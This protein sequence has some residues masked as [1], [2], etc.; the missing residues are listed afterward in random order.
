MKKSL[1]IAFCIVL[2]SSSHVAADKEMWYSI[3]QMKSW[4]N[5]HT[6]DNF[7]QYILNDYLLN[8]QQNYVEERL[9]QLRIDSRLEIQQYGE[10][11]EEQ[12]TEAISKSNYER[13][14]NYSE[15]KKHEIQ[16]GISN[17][18][19]RSLESWLYQKDSTTSP[20]K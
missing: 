2:I 19:R 12:I 17:N 4:I 13:L 11:Y 6:E 14:D 7:K 15:K 20:S 8:H 3:F 9:E 18:V 16:Q 5:E 1:A 10:A